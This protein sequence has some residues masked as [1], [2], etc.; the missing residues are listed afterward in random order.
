M[1][2]YDWSLFDIFLRI[3][4]PAKYIFDSWATAR[5]L[6]S[7]FVAKASFESAQGVVRGGAEHASV[8]D[9]YEWAFIHGP[10]IEGEMCE[11]TR[12]VSLAFTFAS[13]IV[14]IKID[15]LPGGSLLNLRQEGIPTTADAMVNEHINCRGAWIHFMTVLK[16]Q[17]EHGVDGRDVD[18]TTAGSLATRYRPPWSPT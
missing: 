8:G 15:P 4:A 6:V 14:T 16:I 7:F 1:S 10:V 5:G 2:D 17:L 12:D 9:R 11:M 13:G 18:P 3:N